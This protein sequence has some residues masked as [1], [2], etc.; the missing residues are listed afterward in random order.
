MKPIKHLEELPETPISEDQVLTDDDLAKGGLV[1][2]EAWMR[3]K[4][5]KGAL[6][7]KKHREAKEA[8]GMKQLNIVIPEAAREQFKTWAK[9]AE[10]GQPYGPEQTVKTIEVVKTVE[11]VK[12]VQRTDPKADAL[13][14]KVRSLTGWKKALARLLGLLD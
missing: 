6:R 4:S 5:S 9:A 8:E 13:L 3:T 10:E 7:V 2:A 11:V 12:E 14:K 1:K